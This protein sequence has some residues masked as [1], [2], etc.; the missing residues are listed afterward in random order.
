MSLKGCSHAAMKDYFTSA[1]VLQK[2]ILPQP[3][4]YLLLQYGKVETVDKCKGA[5]K[6]TKIKVYI[7]LSQSHQ[8]FL[9]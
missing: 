8:H 4:N 1:L 2:T 3:L 9:N 5:N 6:D 7:C